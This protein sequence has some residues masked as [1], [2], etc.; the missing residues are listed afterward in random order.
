MH[1]VIYLEEFIPQHHLLAAI[2]RDPDV[3]AFRDRLKNF[4]SPIDRPSVDTK[5]IVRMLLSGYCYGI[6][7]ERL[8]CKTVESY[9]SDGISC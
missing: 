4:Y 1:K 5:L 6:R 8:L 2:D 9:R 7:S 3:A